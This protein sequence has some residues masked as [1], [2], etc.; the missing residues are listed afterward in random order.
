MPWKKAY[1]IEDEEEAFFD[2]TENGLT[3]RQAAA[4]HGVPHSSLH[5]RYNKLNAQGL[6]EDDI[7]PAQR[8]SMAQEKLVSQ[9]ILRQEQLGNPPTSTAVKAVAESILRKNGDMAPIGKNWTSSFKRRN[10]EIITK[11]GKY[12]ESLRFTSFSPKAVK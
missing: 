11:I 8:L 10:P 1:T 7:Q 9:W 4:K 6:L 12:Q 2:I 5:R 3:L